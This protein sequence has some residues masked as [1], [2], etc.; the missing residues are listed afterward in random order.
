MTKAPAMVWLE[1]NRRLIEVE[2]SI[3]L[4]QDMIFRDF[5][6]RLIFG[7]FVFFFFGFTKC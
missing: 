4:S 2:C 6:I 7:E 5:D 1:A 3:K